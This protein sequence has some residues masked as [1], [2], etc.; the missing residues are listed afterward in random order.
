MIN[1]ILPTAQEG[2]L[3]TWQVCTLLIL[4]P[5][6]LTLIIGMS[7]NIWTQGR[8]QIPMQGEEIQKQFRRS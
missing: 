7:L 2:L 4:T 8:H 6:I 1:M 5:F 3:P